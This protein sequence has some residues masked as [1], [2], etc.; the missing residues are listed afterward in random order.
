MS[1]RTG[2]GESGSGFAQTSFLMLRD[3]LFEVSLERVEGIRIVLEALDGV[4]HRLAAKPPLRRL[5]GDAENV[6]CVLDEE[7]A[8]DP[9]DQLEDVVVVWMSGSPN[10][11]SRSLS[12]IYDS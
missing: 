1:S 10:G 4:W 12:L 7:S 6:H 9:L 8:G 3:Q 11:S 5:F 2:A